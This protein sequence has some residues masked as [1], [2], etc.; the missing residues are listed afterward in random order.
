MG[1]RELNVGKNLIGFGKWKNTKQNPKNPK[2]SRNIRFDSLQNE[3]K[4]LVGFHHKV[5]VTTSFF[6]YI[7]P[8]QIP[9]R[10]GTYF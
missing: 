9:E 5:A 2:P 7:Q 10:V 3:N 4:K 6:L 1:F 8:T